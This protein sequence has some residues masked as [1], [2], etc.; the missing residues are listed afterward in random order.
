[1]LVKFPEILYLQNF[2]SCFNFAYSCSQEYSLRLYDITQID[3]EQI[4]CEMRFTFSNKENI[5]SKQIP[6][7][8]IIYHPDLHNC[9]KDKTLGKTTNKESRCFRD[10]LQFDMESSALNVKN[11]LVKKVKYNHSLAR[12]ELSEIRYVILN[13]PHFLY[14][15]II[16]VF[17]K[18]YFMCAW[19]YS[20]PLCF[21]YVICL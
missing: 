1:M 11:M 9:A 5:I 20:V 12:T 14:N 4:Q 21:I 10:K 15:H 19:F 13:V 2:V 6:C 16:I 3:C 17:L 7:N 18:F 8:K